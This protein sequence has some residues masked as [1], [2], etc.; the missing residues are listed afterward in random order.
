MASG[1]S[2]LDL[3]SVSMELALLVKK[4]GDWVR[5]IFTFFPA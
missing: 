5:V 2:T 1:H 4:I 3:K